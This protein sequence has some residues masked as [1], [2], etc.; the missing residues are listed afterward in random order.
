MSALAL[1][2][3]A[4][5]ARVGG[6]DHARSEYVELL[7]QRGIAVTAGHAAENVP[8]G[9]E[10]VVSTAVAP[11]NPEVTGRAVTS[12]GELLAE[13]V[14][15]APAIVVAGAHGKTTTAA[16]IAFCLERLGHDPTFLIGGIVPQLGGNAHAGAGWLVTEGDES[17]RS[18]GL[19]A[20]SVAV[21]TNVDLD[22]HATFASRAEVQELFDGWLASLPADAAV[23][24]GAELAPVDFELATPGAH[25]RHNASCALAALEA[26]GF[27]AAAA[28]AEIAAFRGVARR[29]EPHGSPGG[30]RLYDDYGHH[31]AEVAAVLAAARDVAVGHGRVHVIFQPHLFSRTLHL[32]SEFADALAASDT[33]CVTEIYA[34]REEPMPGVSGKLI[35]DALCRRRPGM[36]VMY[37]PQLDDAAAMIAARV[38]PGDTVIT[39]GAGDVGRAALALAER[40]G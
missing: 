36:P 32:H 37:A 28:A 6:S 20:P 12:R 39:M 11:D 26:A 33:V 22:H 13:L 24:N 9:F 31:P 4:R 23:V 10:I 27:D 38:K 25:N 19:L 14:Q 29:L 8:P 1:I 7:E 18:L 15:E 40:L 5:G 35:V 3:D 21:I 16:M 30:V 34:A 17:D 2:A